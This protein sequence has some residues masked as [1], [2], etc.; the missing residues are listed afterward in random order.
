[1]QQLYGL[2]QFSVELATDASMRAA[3]AAAMI[4]GFGHILVTK[5]ICT[6]E[7]LVQAVRGAE[8][9]GAIGAFVAH[10]QET[11][12]EGEETSPYPEDAVIFG[13]GS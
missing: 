5:G 10:M 9:A 3:G 6:G 7:E 13:G 4:S 1:M 2:A 8:A 12:A 11:I